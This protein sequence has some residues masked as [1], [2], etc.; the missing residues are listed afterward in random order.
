MSLDDLSVQYQQ[1]DANFLSVYMAIKSISIEDL[2]QAEDSEYRNI[3]ASSSKPLPF[4]LSPVNN[5]SGKGLRNIINLSSLGL[6]MSHMPGQLP[7]FPLLHLMSSPKLPTSAH[8]PSPT[9]AH[10]PS[11][12]SAHTPSPT[13]AHT[14]SPTSAHTPSPTSAHTPSPTSSHTPSTTSAHTPSTTPPRRSTRSHLRMRGGGCLAS[15]ARRSPQRSLLLS[16]SSSRTRQGL[17]VKTRPPHFQSHTR[18][19]V[20]CWLFMWT[21]NIR[22]SKRNMIQ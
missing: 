2:L 17:L 12:T 15:P 11:P 8:T 13:S 18:I 21:R 3:L 1:S 16:S 10:T 5:H 14:P 19:F 20:L 7:F 22:C 4:P 6:P 9:S